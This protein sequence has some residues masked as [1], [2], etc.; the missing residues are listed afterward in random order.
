MVSLM[1]LGPIVHNSKKRG[2]KELSYFVMEW[3]PKYD[4]ED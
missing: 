1:R 4:L 2:C 3:A